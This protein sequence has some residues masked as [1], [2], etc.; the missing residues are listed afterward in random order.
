MD[1]RRAMTKH[2]PLIL[3]LALAAP[4]PIA[5]IAQATTEEEA[6]DGPSLMERG[7][8]IFLRGLMA[9]MEPALQD[10]HSKFEEVEPAIRSFV[11]EMGPAV[12]E[13]LHTVKDFRGYHPPEILP[14]GDIIM[15][16]KLPQEMEIPEGGE[17]EVG[18]GGEV[19]L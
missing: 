7:A 15:R 10:L 13:L 3:L 17:V 8:R 11:E 18:P 16:K 4:L 12:V 19:E 1:Y 6:D 5:A 14:N 9:E 2:M